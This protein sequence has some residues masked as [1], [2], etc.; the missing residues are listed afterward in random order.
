MAELDLREHYVVAMRKGHPAAERFDLDHWL[1][2]PHVLFPGCGH[3]AGPLHEALAGSGR[4]RRIGMVVPAFSIVPKLLESSDLVAILSSRCIP[5]EEQASLEVFDATLPVDGF[6][7]H[8]AWHERADGDRG[9]RHVT[10]ILRRPPAGS[11]PP[12]K[13]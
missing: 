13:L 9:T 10:G 6:L 1:A 3:R 2:H 7:L 8:L 11:S 5:A 4:E 12:E